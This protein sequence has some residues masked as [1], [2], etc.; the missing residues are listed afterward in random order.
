MSAIDML[1]DRAPPPL[2]ITPY[3]E[4]LLDRECAVVNRRAAAA[5][6]GAS[7]TAEARDLLVTAWRAAGMHADVRPTI[8]SGLVRFVDEPEVRQVLWEGLITVDSAHHLLGEAP[9]LRFPGEAS[10]R[11]AVRRGFVALAESLVDS[12]DPRLAAA[13]LRVCVR[14]HD[15]CSE[16]LAPARRH[17]TH[18]ATPA[19]V[20]AAVTE[21]LVALPHAAGLPTWQAALADLTVA[22]ATR[23]PWATQRLARFQVGERPWRVALA[24]AQ[25]TAGIHLTATA[26]YRRVLEADLDGGRIDADLWSTYLALV[27]EQ[28]ARHRAWTARLKDAAA[29]GAAVDLLLR[30]GG[31]SAALTAA[32][33]LT[34][35]GA[36][37]TSEPA[38]A[39]RAAA[40]SA[41]H[42][43]AAER[44]L[45]A[46]GARP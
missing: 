26:S 16:G 3:R 8:L 5:R 25:R 4:L 32:D 45:L 2:D 34:S 43:D 44:L 14:E 9:I 1:A 21:A 24:E 29:A 22:A 33:L 7:A 46:E 38:W 13:A 19:P 18:P 17:L 15:L 20:L 37:V 42:V 28:P 23:A 27:D 11:P 41:I 12:P 39:A 36:S 35:L 10:V 31:I 30:Q 6:V 40:I